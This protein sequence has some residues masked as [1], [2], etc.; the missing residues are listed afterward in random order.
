MFE[1]VTALLHDLDEGMVPLSVMFP[2]APIK[3][4]RVRDK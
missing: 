4:H 1:Q 3:V 2:Y